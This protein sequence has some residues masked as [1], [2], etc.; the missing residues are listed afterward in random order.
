M[1]RLSVFA[2]RVSELNFE[3]DLDADKDTIFENVENLSLEH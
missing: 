3:F 1:E 2:V